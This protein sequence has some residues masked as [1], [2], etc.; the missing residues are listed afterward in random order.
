MYKK[1][2]TDHVSRQMAIEDTGHRGNISMERCRRK[3]KVFTTGNKND[4]EGFCWW[5]SHHTWRAKTYVP[6]K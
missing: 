2:E 3:R 5:N 1:Q 4:S 6:C